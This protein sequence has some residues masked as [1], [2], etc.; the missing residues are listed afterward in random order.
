MTIAYVAF[1]VMQWIK[2]STPTTFDLLLIPLII[3][4]YVISTVTHNVTVGIILGWAFMLLVL[5]LLSG[6]VYWFAFVPHSKRFWYSLVGA[7]FVVILAPTL[8]QWYWHRNDQPFSILPINERS[9]FIFTLLA[10]QGAVPVADQELVIN[11]ETEYEQLLHHRT[12]TCKDPLPP[13]DF[14]KYTVLG[15][16]VTDASCM[17]NEFSRTYSRDDAQKTATYAVR[18]V[19]RFCMTAMPSDSMNLIA[20]PKIPPDYRINFKPGPTTC[21]DAT[22]ANGRPYTKCS[23]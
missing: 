15:K 19:E 14:S 18:S 23:Q 4:S 20:V 13:V 12:S 6:S 11:T 9:C 8:L 22:F 16:L 1:Y 3:P 7:C 17:R 5:Y 10:P 21:V 2:P